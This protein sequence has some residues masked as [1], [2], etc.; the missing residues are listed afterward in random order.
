MASGRQTD[1]WDIPYLT[2]DCL[3]QD[4]YDISAPSSKISAPD[5]GSIA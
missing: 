1:D 5:L 3:R 2:W 4:N